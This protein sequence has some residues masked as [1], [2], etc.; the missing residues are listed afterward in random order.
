MP[1]NALSTPTIVSAG[2][3][4]P[5]RVSRQEFN[6]GDRIALTQSGGPGLSVPIEAVDKLVVA[7]LR[8]V[9]DS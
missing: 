5:I 6:T 8:A 4:P 2:A 3:V 9:A 7:L 1:A